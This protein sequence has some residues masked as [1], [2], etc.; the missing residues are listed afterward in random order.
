MSLKEKEK[1]VLKALI[2]GIPLVEEPFKEMAEKLGISEEEF[3]EIAENLLK[4]GYL[5][6]I[7]ATLR[8]NLVG[9]SGNAMVV[10]QVPEERVEEV[11]RFFSSKSFISHC[12]LR[13]ASPD[14]PYNLYTMIHAKKEEEIL[15]LVQ[16]LAEE[17]NLKKYEILFTEKEI[18]R[19]YVSYF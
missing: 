16:K 10:W 19:K 1:R 12:Y 11:G 8:H 15:E 17:L 9:Y 3:L 6:R 18:T 13:E 7:G 2:E 4:K 5:R 14:W